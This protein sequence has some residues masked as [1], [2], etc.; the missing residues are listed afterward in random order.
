MPA[1]QPKKNQNKIAT[2]K[3]RT[4]GWLH[5]GGEEEKEDRQEANPPSMHKGRKG[6]Y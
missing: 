3:E 1:A 5:R 4:V 6:R 2:L